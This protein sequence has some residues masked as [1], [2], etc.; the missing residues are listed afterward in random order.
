MAQ[1]RAQVVGDGITERLQFMVGGLQLRGAFGDALL[2]Y[3]IEPVDLM[4]RQFALVD[5]LPQL[6]VRPFGGFGEFMLAHRPQDQR[7]VQVGDVQT[8]PR[9]AGW[10]AAGHHGWVCPH[11][12]TWSPLVPARPLRAGRSVP[13]TRWSVRYNRS[14]AGG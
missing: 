7:L 6:R 4:F 5:F 8:A 13:A 10:L 11:K 9:Q 3:R 14:D 2:Q 1:R 12:F